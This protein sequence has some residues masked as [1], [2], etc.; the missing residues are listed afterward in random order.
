MGA[1]FGQHPPMLAF[2][3]TTPG[4]VSLMSDC[5]SFYEIRIFF[6]EF[7]DR[8]ICLVCPNQNV[9]TIWANFSTLLVDNV[10]SIRYNSINYRRKHVK[11]LCYRESLSGLSESPAC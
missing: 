4:C 5:P 1:G 6:Q 3:P 10:R 11:A 8:A 2:A 9:I 7:Q